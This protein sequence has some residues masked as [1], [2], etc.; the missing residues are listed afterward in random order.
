MLPGGKLSTGPGP[1]V[2]ATSGNRLYVIEFKASDS[3]RAL[4]SAAAQVRNYVEMERQKVSPDFR[5]TPLIIVPYSSSSMG[6]YVFG[7]PILRFN[8]NKR[9]F[10]NPEIITFECQE[11]QRAEPQ[12]TQNLFPQWIQES[13]NQLNELLT[14]L[15][16]SPFRDGY[17]IFAYCVTGDFE[18]PTRSEL[19]QILRRS[20]GHETGWPAWW[21]PGR[22]GIKPYPQGEDVIECWLGK[23]AIIAGPG[24]S[25]F[26]RASRRGLLYLA[27]GYQEDEITEPGTG[28]EV[29]IPVWQSGSVS[30]T[31]NGLRHYSSKARLPHLST[32]P[33]MD[34]VVESSLHTIQEASSLLRQLRSG[35]TMISSWIERCRELTFKHPC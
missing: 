2:I 6:D 4:D 5:I 26:W 16:R 10:V 17:W 23:E 3:K 21:I 24:H 20:Q 8:I 34:F 9:E 30:C 31:P 28:I 11:T 32:S 19:M 27:R 12:Q 13:D 22:E 29:S 15:E 25:D 33:G 1:D 18:I 35:A 14:Q 7:V